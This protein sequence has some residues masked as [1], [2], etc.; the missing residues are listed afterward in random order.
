MLAGDWS[1]FGQSLLHALKDT[2]QNQPHADSQPLTYLK[3]KLSQNR[4]LCKPKH[5]KVH[6]R[7]VADPPLWSSSKG[8]SREDDQLELL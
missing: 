1:S 4:T 8:M 7:V 2:V 3:S 5:E 6:L